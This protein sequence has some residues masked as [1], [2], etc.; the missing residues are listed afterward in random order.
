[1]C[2]SKDGLCRQLQT[3]SL[4]NFSNVQIEEIAIKDGLHTTSNNGNKVKEAL[5]VIAIAPI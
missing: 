2:E 3:F 5:K 4:D 1:M